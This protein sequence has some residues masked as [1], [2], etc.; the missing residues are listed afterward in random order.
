MAKYWEAYFFL[1]VSLIHLQIDRWANLQAR[2]FASFFL[3][4][5]PGLFNLTDLYGS[6]QRSIYPK[7]AEAY[8]RQLQWR[9]RPDTW[10]THATSCSQRNSG[11][12]SRTG[13]AAGSSS[14]KT[15]Q[16]QLCCWQPYLWQLQSAR[17][18]T[19]IC[20][21]Q[22]DVSHRSLIPHYNA[23]LKSLI[24]SAVETYDLSQWMATFLW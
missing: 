6:K 12:R 8:L 16:T 18:C 22:R 14:A 3:D 11:Y 5:S 10:L 1:H 4:S 24:P 2:I 19:S 15:I 23:G 13:L 21:A 20:A 7:R 9:G 17:K